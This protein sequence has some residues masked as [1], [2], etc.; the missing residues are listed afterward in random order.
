MAI[1]YPNQLI[2]HALLGL[3]PLALS[4]CAGGS[5]SKGLYAGFG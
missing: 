2:R 3:A 5:A 1:H 4:A